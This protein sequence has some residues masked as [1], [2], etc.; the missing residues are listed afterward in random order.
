MARSQVDI[1]QIISGSA[2]RQVMLASPPQGP[3]G[4]VW[5]DSHR[6]GANHAQRYSRRRPSVT[7]AG[8]DPENERAESLK[9]DEP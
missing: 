3:G 7:R 2:L 6:E 1:G 5:V 8:E 9:G 4:A